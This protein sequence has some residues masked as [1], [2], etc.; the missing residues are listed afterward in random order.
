[1][2]ITFYASCAIIAVVA[3]LALAGCDEKKP[4]A[5]PTAPPV[6]ADCQGGVHSV[7][8]ADASQL[9]GFRTEWQSCTAPKADNPADRVIP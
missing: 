8:V 7:S 5:K 3:T 1:M 4:A 9:G 2:K 6:A